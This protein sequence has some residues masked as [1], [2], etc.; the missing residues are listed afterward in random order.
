L[1]ALKVHLLADLL[2]VWTALNLVDR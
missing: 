1:A 2:A